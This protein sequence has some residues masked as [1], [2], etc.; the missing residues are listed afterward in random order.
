MRRRGIARMWKAEKHADRLLA[1]SIVCCYF[2]LPVFL[3]SYILAVCDQDV[4]VGGIL[5]LRTYHVYEPQVFTMPVWSLGQVHVRTELSC[6]YFLHF[7]RYQQYFYMLNALPNAPW[8]VITDYIRSDHIT[9][10]NLK[11]HMW[12]IIDWLKVL[13]PTLHRIG[14]YRDVLP[15]WSLGIVLKKLIQQKQTIEEQTHKMLKWNKCTKTKPKPKPTLIFKNCSYVCA[16][17]YA[18]L[19][20]TTQPR[21]VLISFLILHTK[22]QPS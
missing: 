14:H 10:K 18:Q 5:L 13:H 7:H 16:Y 12:T 4:D 11:H 19:S 6:G 9:F 8:T 2:L 3:L 1:V 17:H 21:T 15:I 22:R 20:Y